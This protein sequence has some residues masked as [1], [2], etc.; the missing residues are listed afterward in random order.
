AST[1]RE[2]VLF[3]MNAFERRIIHTELAKRSDVTTESTGAGD[4][5]KVVVRPV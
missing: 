4:N 5:R 3:P 2:K 1:G